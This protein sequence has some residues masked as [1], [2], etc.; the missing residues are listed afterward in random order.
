MERFLLFD[1]V[2]AAE[3]EATAQCEQRGES[4]QAPGEQLPTGVGLSTRSGLGQR[5]RCRG[6]H[7]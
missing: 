6:Y 5:V 7:C 1:T 3:H 2:P 4:G